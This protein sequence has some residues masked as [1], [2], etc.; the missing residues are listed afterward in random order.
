M[1]GRTAA[2]AAAAVVS[3]GALASVA[4]AA[5]GPP[6]PSATNGAKVKLVATGVRT[7]T[8]F[9]FGG[10]TVFEG[11]GGNKEKGV[12]NGGVFVL[13]GGKAK[14]LK[15]SPPFVGGLT[16]HNGTLYVSCGALSKSGVSWQLQ[17]WSGWNGKRF[18]KQKVIWTA[19]KKLDG[20]NGIAFGSDGRLYVGVDVGLLHQGDHGPAVTPYVYK[21]LSFK[22]NGSD[23]KVFA[24]GIRQPW[25]FAF[26]S[27][28]SSPYVSDLGQD[29]GA[30][31]PPD[32][33]LK[34]KQ[35]DNYGFPKCNWINSSACKGFTKPFTRFPPHSDIM[36]LAIIGNKL[37]M[38]S[39]VGHG[40]SHQG[41]E[42]YSM[43]LK[44]GT[45]TPVVTG[46]VAP[47]VGLGANKGTLYIG[48]L[49]GQVFSVR[50]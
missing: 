4:V 19:P 10:G 25:Q 13:K 40:P 15:G 12:P 35:G 20:L 42:V 41:G 37:Y 38:T 31:N 28:S 16:W 34:V 47:T 27:G 8:S 24:S 5:G 11:D 17:A 6:P 1:W 46:F 39:F 22:R 33:V 29:S 45:Y 2:I 48:E 9:A 21:I 30:K 43:P 49:S 32:F 36:G 50:P 18:A 3:T 44:G 23:L 26:A 14:L 7:P